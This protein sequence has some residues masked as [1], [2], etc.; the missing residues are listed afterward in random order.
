MRSTRRPKSY[1]IRSR[2]TLIFIFITAV[3]LVSSASAM[4]AITNNDRIACGVRFGDTPLNAMSEQ[5]TAHLLEDY[6]QKQ[7]AHGSLILNYKD[8]T[9]KILPQDINLQMDAKSTA[10]RAFAIGH[11]GSALQKLREQLVCMI[12]GQQIELAVSYDETL[13]QKKLDAIAQEINTAPVSA[14]CTIDNKGQVFRKPAVSGQK[15]DTETVAQEAAEPL[16]HLD[17]PRHIALQPE[18]QAAA[19]T[20]NDL[21]AVDSI[22]S[23]FSTHFNSGNASRSTNIYIAA[24]ALNNVLVKSDANFSFND[25]VGHRVSSSGYRS[26]AVILNGKVA[27]DIGG[28]V[29][30]V[31]STLYN[32]VLLANLQS[33]V[34]TSHFYPSSYVRA[35]LDATVA[36]GQLD[37]QFHNN[38]PHNVYILSSVYGNTLTIYVLGT[39]ADLGGMNIT[40][41]TCTE[42]SGPGPVVSAYRIYRQNGQEITREFL[43]TDHYDV[44]T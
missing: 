36:D 32:A 5:E 20:D 19:V 43:H 35:G 7:L 18:E 25:T 33:T 39:K 16:L 27:Q 4:L 31:S 14:T 2:F 12:R 22:L 23:S 1:L 28:G 29:C 42:R 3:L 37:F 10:A 11:Q 21:S 26:A 44:P 40:L 24:N 13:L 6:A 38:L 41:E 9:W 34:R 8:K 30:Q 17:L 15:L